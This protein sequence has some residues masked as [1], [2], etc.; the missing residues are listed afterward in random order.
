M[1]VQATCGRTGGTKKHPIVTEGPAVDEEWGNN[2]AHAEIRGH[3]HEPQPIPVKHF[4]DII[5]YEIS[6]EST[7][8]V[9]S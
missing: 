7:H 3:D 5:P 9:K 1:V 4:W 2:L 8:T 6:H